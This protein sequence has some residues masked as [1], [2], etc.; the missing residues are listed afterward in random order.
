MD[1]KRN[2][3]IT[4]GAKRI[5]AKISEILAS[6]GCNVIIHYNK[7]ST[8]AQKLCKKINKYKK[9][10]I[11]VQ[12]DLCIEEEIKKAFKI[13]QNE[14]GYINCIINNAS[15]FEYDNLKTVSKKSWNDHIS[16]NLNGPLILSKLFY[17]NLPKNNY[18]DI[19]NIL[20][21]RVLNLTPH[22]LSYTISKSALWTLTQTLALEL[23]PKIKVNAIG[24]GPVIKSK[25]QTEKEFIKQCKKMP[26]QIGSNPN[27][28]AQTV[29]FLLTIPSITGQ[30]I[31]LDGGQH[32]GW[33]QVSNNI[34]LKD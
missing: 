14:F 32:L 7:S 2:V 16:A 9:S 18:G 6:K 1:I 29:I 17:K 21:Q 12:A 28:I 3:F 26:L 20:D 8:A 33:G 23:A 5:G 15:L 13:A 22:F 10:A 34:K 24:P 4:G 25:F 30:L 31:T 11:S 19:I 27:E